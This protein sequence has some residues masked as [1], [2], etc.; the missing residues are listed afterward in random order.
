MLSL[1]PL[2]EKGYA[3]LRSLVEL[4]ERGVSTLQASIQEVEDRIA[5]LEVQTTPVTLLHLEA[6]SDQDELEALSAYLEDSP[7]PLEPYFQVLGRNQCQADPLAFKPTLLRLGPERGD[8]LL[9]KKQEDGHDRLEDAVL[10]RYDRLEAMRFHQKQ[11]SSCGLLVRAGPSRVANPTPECIRGVLNLDIELACLRGQKHV[12]NQDN[13]SMLQ[14]HLA[15]RGPHRL[16]VLS[17]LDGHGDN[18]HWVSEKL[19]QVLPSFVLHALREY[20]LQSGVEPDMPQVFHTAFENAHLELEAFAIQHELDLRKSGSCA[21]VAVRLPGGD[22]TLHCAWVGDSQVAVIGKD[23]RTNFVSWEHDISGKEGERVAAAGGM[24][25]D[26]GPGLGGAPLLRIYRRGDDGPG[27]AIS[28]AFG[29]WSASDLGVTW[30]PDYAKAR[31]EPGCT[32][33][34]GSDGLWDCLK[35]PEVDSFRPGPKS[36]HSWATALIRTSL[37]R[38]Q[39]MCIP[40]DDTTCMLWHV[41]E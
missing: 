5:S 20:D 41:S 12:V 11:V 24:I 34:L 6:E 9:G 25:V 17:V 29:D 32:V 7:E 38:R 14:A 39:E 23:G 18:G 33:V 8:L 16:T 35:A 15:A 37:Q 3:E 19:S 4:H 22:D 2:E 40:A 13:F 31:L 1:A 30:E 21:V 27:L 28:R 26:K 10:G 36:D